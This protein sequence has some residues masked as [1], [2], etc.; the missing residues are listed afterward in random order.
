MARPALRV[1]N[2][3]K[4]YRIGVEDEK[5]ETLVGA[6]GSWVTGPLTNYRRLRDL[7]T[8]SDEDGED[9]IWALRDVSF[10]IQ[11]GEVV[12]FIGRN[13]AGKSTLLKLLSRIAYPTT[14]HIELVGRVSSLLEVG[15]GFNTELTGRENVFLNGTILGMTK[16]EVAQK[17]DEIVEFSGV[18]KFIDTPVKRYSSG[19]KVRL[20]FAVAAHLEPDILIVD[21]VLAVGDVAFKKK[22]LGKM[23]EVSQSG[24]TVLYV[25]HEM[26]TVTNLCQRAYVMDAGRIVH[27]AP[28]QDAVEWYLDDMEV[29]DRDNLRLGEV[30]EE[31]RVGDGRLRFTASYLENRKG[32]HTHAPISGDPVDIVLEYEAQE[33][34]P[35]V[36]FWVTISNHLGVP[37]AVCHMRSHD[38]YYHVRE[39]RGRVR[40]HLPRL[41]LPNGTYQVKLDAKDYVRRKHLDSVEAALEFEVSA[42][43]FFASGYVP[44]ASNSTVLMEHTWEHEEGVDAPV[45]QS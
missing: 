22:C 32:H 25:S 44:N 14:G 2:L 31:E 30:A 8:F 20:G 34:L 39:G 21:E 4:R 42:S 17:F 38:T 13:G 29:I 9:V 18:G 1:E 33:E 41:P 5:H 37:V 40:C 45:A 27:E 3:G 35:R 16:A 6:L 23:D 10:E 28:V 43:T 24:R 19:M 26:S 7:S 12:G 11:P 36:T 15:T